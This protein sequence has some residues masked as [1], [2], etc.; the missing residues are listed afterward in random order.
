[1]TI[2]EAR[3]LAHGD[4]HRHVERRVQ[5]MD[6]D[7]VEAGER[8]ALQQHGADVAAELAARHQ[9]DQRVGGVDA[10]A[11]DLA[12]QHAVEPGPR[13]HRADHAHV[14]AMLVRERR[15][16]EADDVGDGL[17]RRRYSA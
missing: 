9:L 6:V 12:R 16:I 3:V 7:D 4:H 17:H 5:P 1:L 2:A 10:V 15:V 13:A 8:D 14:A 11:A